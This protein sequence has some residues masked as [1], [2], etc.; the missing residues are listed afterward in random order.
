[1]TKAVYQS[2]FISLSALLLAVL[3][4]VQPTDSQDMKA[5]QNQIKE[6][7]AQASMQLLRGPN[8]GEPFA[9]VWSSVDAFYAESATAAIALLQNDALSDLALLFDSNYEQ[10]MEV[11][12]A[13]IVGR[14][15]EPTEEALL[16]IVPYDENEYLLDPYF[17]DDLVY[18][19][20]EN[21]EVSGIVAGESIDA[22]D[23]PADSQVRS[24]PEEPL[25]QRPPVTW[26][27]ITDS[28]T[29]QPNCVAI[30]NG[31]INAYAGPC[32]KEDAIIQLYEN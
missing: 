23:V 28:I 8:L 9:L 17:N 11:A 22:S 15:I 12:F 16:N 13:P 10:N 27:T 7:F 1:M 18:M 24:Q 29:G 32:A 31:T 14:I 20:D 19:L 5:F 26:M 4:V 21:G 25:V 30:F 2:M 3:F 6:Q